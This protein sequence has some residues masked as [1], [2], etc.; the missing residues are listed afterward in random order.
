MSLIL[1]YPNFV[2]SAIDLIISTQVIS[3][4]LAY[5]FTH[6][7]LVDCTLTISIH[8]YLS[9]LTTT[10]HSHLNNLTTSFHSHLSD[11][12][13]LFTVISLIVPYSHTAYFAR[14]QRSGC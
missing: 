8:S 10:F 3:L 2:T 9:D 13:H 7:H 14:T 6:S 12:A 4:I 11:H 1:L 5:I